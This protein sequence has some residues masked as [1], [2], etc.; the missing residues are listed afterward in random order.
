MKKNSTVANSG[1]K[2]FTGKKLTIGLGSGGS[3]VVLLRY[4]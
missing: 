2:I 4:G 1:K 3:L